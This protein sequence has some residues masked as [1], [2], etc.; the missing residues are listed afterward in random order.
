MSAA[1]P[2]RPPVVSLRRERVYLRVRTRFLLSVF[3][4]LVWSTFSFWL[5]L[6]WIAELARSITLP[7]AIVVV[8]GIAIVPGYLNFQL[9]A[10]LLLDRPPALRL[11]GPFPPVAILIAAYN[12]AERIEETLT[13][14]LRQDYPGGLEVL[15]LDDGS[16]DGTAEIVRGRAA[17]DRRIRLLQLPHGGKAVALNAGL[18][19]ATAALVATIDADTLLMPFALRRVV[20]RLMAAPASTVAV[21]G[22]VL[23]RNSRSNLLARVQ[24]W[25]YF[26]GI[27]AVKRQQALLQGTLVAQGAFSLYDTD[28]LRAAGGWPDRIGEDI[29]LT[30]TL[31]A[32]GGL[33]TFEPTAVAFT[34][35]PVRF[36]GFRKQRQRWARGMIEGL[37]DHGLTLLSEGRLPS[38]SVGANF[39]FPY[40]D[41]VYTCAFLPGVLLALTGNFALVGPLTLAVLPLSALVAGIMFVRQRRAFDEVGLKVRRNRLGFGAY[42]ALYPAVLAPISFAGYVKELAGAKRAW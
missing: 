14:A 35:V 39:L 7:G 41:G 12:E 34:D 13:Y 3:A 22:A 29:V 33:T 9:A 10:A 16:T 27:S 28:A 6:P 15:V 42:I 31:L 37:R 24:E 11:E 17:R 25:D 26:L 18:E 38:H 32:R 2:L 20:G 19:A 5:S 23:V 36:G 40:L 8:F 4:G 1:P 21:A 30:W